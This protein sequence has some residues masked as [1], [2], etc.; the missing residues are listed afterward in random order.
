VH[1][2]AAECVAVY[3]ATGIRRVRWT[4]FNDLTLKHTEKDFVERQTVCVCLFVCVV[5]DPYAIVVHGINDVL[6]PHLAPTFR[7]VAPTE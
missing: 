1:G 2:F 6:D 3:Q 5:G 7:E 4:I